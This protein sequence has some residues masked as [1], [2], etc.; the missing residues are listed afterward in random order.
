MAFYRTPSN[1]K[2]SIL[3]FVKRI[4]DKVLY[5]AIDVILSPCCDLTATAEATC[6]D[7]NDFDIVITT[8][9]SIGFLGKGISTVTIDNVPYTGI[10]TEPTEIFVE[11]AAV[12]AGTYDVNI[13]IFL[14]TNSDGT[15]GVF[16]TITVPD[17][18]FIECV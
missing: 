7:S 12:G 14:P 5:R 11:G 3:A 18:E 13:V 15:V 6:T 2:T 4:V 17:V 8:N 16:K 10:V 9:P 1:L